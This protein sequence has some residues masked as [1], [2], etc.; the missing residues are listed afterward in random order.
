MLKRSQPSVNPGSFEQKKSRRNLSELPTEMID[1]FGRS[2]DPSIFVSFTLGY[3]R[4][5]EL[6]QSTTREGHEFP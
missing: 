5:A 2:I 6:A 4:D 3:D 1:S